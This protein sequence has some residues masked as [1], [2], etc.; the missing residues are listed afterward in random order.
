M[1]TQAD[2]NGNMGHTEF[3]GE[4][5]FVNTDNQTNKSSEDNLVCPQ[6]AHTHIRSDEMSCRSTL[7]EWRRRDGGMPLD[8]LTS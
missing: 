6:D 8:A 3:D 1:S 4:Q 7:I 5:G 2:T